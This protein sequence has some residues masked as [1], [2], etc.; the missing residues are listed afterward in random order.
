MT[1]SILEMRGISKSFPGV[2]VLKDVTLTL[3]PG[4][5]H[6]LMGE[7]GAGK[8]TLMKILMGIHAPDAGSILIDGAQE[9]ITDPSRAIA[10]GIA[11]IHQELNPVLDM[12]VYENIFLGREL[13]RGGL[14]DHSRMRRRTAALL[15]S[16]GIAIPPDA[17]MRSLSVA[18][19]Q[20]V[21][22]AKALSAGARIVI[23]DEPTSA[24]TDD[25]V[26]AL[27]AQIAALKGKGVGIIYISHKMDEIFRIADRIT[28][29]R[30]GELI[31]VDDASELDEKA[32]ITA[33]V[34][35][36][37]DDVF[38]KRRVPIGAPV[39]QVSDWAVD[40]RIAGIDLEV[41]AGEI[42]GIGGLVGAGRSELVESLFG[43][44]A[45]RS[46]RMVK[47]GQEI[48]VRRPA[49][50]IRHGIAL[51]TEDRKRTGLNLE[52]S[53]ATNIALPS[54]GR[55]FGNGMV[56][57]RVESRLAEKHV[58]RLGIRT[59]S[60]RRRCATLSGGNQQKVVLAKWLETDP[61]V[62][63]LDDPTRGIDIGAK[64]DIYELIGELVEQGKAVILISSEMGEL[65][66][67]SDRV[68]VLAEGRMTGALD[69]SQFSQEAV[70]ELASR[71]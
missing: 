3:R 66:G 8:S 9:R 2:T 22:I 36:T 57:P 70:M 15:D 52:G 53:V 54:L 43:M 13:R 33:M 11:M 49:D 71:F 31:R 20:Q 42:L 28:V 26:E 55:L 10:L 45:H 30:D 21:E 68:I 1:G 51:I 41:R 44:R 62:I 29:L 17:L 24:I 27:F 4:E 25:D 56:R 59:P 39:L 34:G 5:V 63:I 69:S 19:C 32:L 46:G 40:E 65:L 23:M 16:M 18:Q 38:P 7:N 37:L 47:D 50:A 6:A 12:P 35:R 61:D 58:S 14:A 64:R 48:T 60:V 67:L